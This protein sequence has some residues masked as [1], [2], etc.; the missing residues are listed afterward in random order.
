MKWPSSISILGAAP[1]V[2]VLMGAPPAHA[3]RAT[4]TLNDTGMTRCVSPALTSGPLD[5]VSVP[6]AR[7][8]QDGE[9]G[10]DVEQPDPSDGDAGFVYTRICGSGQAA[11]TGNCPAVPAPG[12]GPDDWACTR[13]EVTDLLWEVKTADGGPRD[14]GRMFTNLQPGTSGYGSS[15]DAAGFVAEANS[16][17]LCGSQAWHLPGVTEIQSIVDFGFAWRGVP[18][19]DSQYFPNWQSQF[20]TSTFTP[21]AA[22]EAYVQQGTGGTV[23]WDRAT[24]YSVQLVSGGSAPPAG[25]SRWRVSRDGQEITDTQTGLVWQ[26]CPQGQYWNGTTCDGSAM[27]FAFYDAI[28][29]A[30]NVAL[31]SP[32][33][34]RLP[35]VKELA[36]LLDFTQQ[37]PEY[38]TPLIDPAAFPAT[39]ADFFWTSTPLQIE[40]APSAN[41]DASNGWYVHFG[42]GYIFQGYLTVSSCLRLVRRAR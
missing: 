16:G 7:T 19:I 30:K 10:R 5:R 12:P 35:N 41:F 26:R 21:A 23:V 3:A 37:G 1:A 17:H 20:W 6:C 38:F 4:P 18:A 27:R 13:D 2:L 39:P 24:T 14:L 34:W 9:T 15:S 31:A 32:K 36:S 22:D 25:T 42:Y 11:G 29:H 8:G 40:Q 33:G 28:A